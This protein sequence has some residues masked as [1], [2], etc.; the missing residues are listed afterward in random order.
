MILDYIALYFCY[1]S[2]A[3]KVLLAVL[4]I[5]VLLV[6]ASSRYHREFNLTIVVV[7]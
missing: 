3:R 4:V 2:V 7:E 1:V 5:P 6:S